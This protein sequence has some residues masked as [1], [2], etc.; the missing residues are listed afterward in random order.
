M[1]ITFQILLLSFGLFLN[2]TTFAAAYFEYSPTS[3][4]KNSIKKENLKNVKK[5]WRKPN[6]RIKKENGKH[7]FGGIISVILGITALFA[8]LKLSNLIAW[9]WLWV[10][11]PIWITLVL[12]ILIIIYVIILFLLMPPPPQIEEI[13]LEEN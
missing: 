11:S 4:L 6:Y 2:Q 1:K 9:S 10:I 12:V 13:P 7:G 5:N 8:V 3:E